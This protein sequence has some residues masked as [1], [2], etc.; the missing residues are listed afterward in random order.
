MKFNSTLRKRE[1]I[2][3]FLSD[4]MVR[5]REDHLQVTEQDVRGVIGMRPQVLLEL[6][7]NLC[8]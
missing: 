1:I 5:E 7:V 4:G 2:L 8:T 3:G 6:R